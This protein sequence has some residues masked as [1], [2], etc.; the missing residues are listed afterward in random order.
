MKKR[1]DWCGRSVSGRSEAGYRFGDPPWWAMGLKRDWA[2]TVPRVHFYF[3]FFF[4]L[5]LFSDF[6]ISFV[7]FAN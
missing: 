4:S 1:T 6:L 7:S 3:Y 5:F 2:E